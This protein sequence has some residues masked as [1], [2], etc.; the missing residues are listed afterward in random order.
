LSTG[1]QLVTVAVVLLVNAVRTDFP[2]LQVLFW[3]TLVL[4]VASA[5]HYVY[6]T[7]VRRGAPPA[8]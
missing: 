6:L 5:L 2:A 8:R 3:L 7:S 1:S 4:T